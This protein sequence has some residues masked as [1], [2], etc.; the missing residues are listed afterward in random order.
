MRN[1]FLFIEKMFS[2]TIKFIVGLMFAA[3]IFEAVLWKPDTHSNSKNPVD[4]SCYCGFPK[5]LLTTQWRSPFDVQR[6][7]RSAVSGVVAIFLRINQSPHSHPSPTLI[8]LFFLFCRQLHILHLIE[9]VSVVFH[10]TGMD[11]SMIHFPH[12]WS[13]SF[14]WIVGF[15]LP[16]PLFQA[17]FDGD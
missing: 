13:V 15:S 10:L 9:W 4:S 16:I 5:Q 2:I 3:Q 11:S 17:L 8:D 1:V 6:V 12:V 7:G 14:Y